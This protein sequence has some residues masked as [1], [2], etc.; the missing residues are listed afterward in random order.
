MKLPP[1]VQRLCECH[2]SKSKIW[3]SFKD[4]DVSVYTKINMF[5]LYLVNQYQKA[6]FVKGKNYLFLHFNSGEKQPKVMVN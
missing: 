1:K 2:L 5:I 4:S 3:D 6:L